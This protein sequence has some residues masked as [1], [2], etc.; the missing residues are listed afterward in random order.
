M[1]DDL[2]TFD[3][4]EN[5]STTPVMPNATAGYQNLEAF[6][7][8][9]EAFYRNLAAFYR[10]LEAFKNSAKIDSNPRNE[11]A[12]TNSTETNLKARKGDSDSTVAKLD[13]SSSSI[14]EDTD[15]ERYQAPYVPYVRYIR[16]DYVPSDEDMRGMLH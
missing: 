14:A 7:G 8:N 2:I 9:L 6:Y 13:T 16:D 12:I 15:Y 5:A 11:E 3:N 1:P 4:D 10:N